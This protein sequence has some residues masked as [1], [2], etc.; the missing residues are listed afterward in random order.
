MNRLFSEEEI[1]EKFRPYVSKGKLF[2]IIEEMKETKAVIIPDNATNGDMIETMFPNVNFGT[3]TQDNVIV[4]KDYSNNDEPQV[5]I[6]IRVWN[7]PYKAESE[8]KK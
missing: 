7:T 2:E 4:N 6:P 8:D 3:L 1:Y 5:F